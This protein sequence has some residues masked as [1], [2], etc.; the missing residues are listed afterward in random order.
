M[1]E[2]LK[3]LQS[4]RLLRL[5][6]LPSTTLVKAHP[7]SEFDEGLGPSKGQTANNEIRKFQVKLSVEDKLEKD[8]PND[9]PCMS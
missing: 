2:D 1:T 5:L 4:S 9:N 7:W 8:V 3:A 6:V